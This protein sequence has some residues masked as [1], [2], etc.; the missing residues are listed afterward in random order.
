[1]NE[2]SADPIDEASALEI[3]TSAASAAAIRSQTAPQVYRHHDGTVETQG[4][5]PDGSWV[6]PD[7]VDCGIDLPLPR[8]N[9]GRIRCVGCQTV[10]ERGRRGYR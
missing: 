6:I 9:L 4:Q 8:L 2:R 3:K 1:M 10:E 7:C 5:M